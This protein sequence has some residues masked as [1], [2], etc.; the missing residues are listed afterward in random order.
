MQ[1][2][3]CSLWWGYCAQRYVVR[4]L[5]LTKDASE[6]LCN[7]F[8]C[9]DHRASDKRVGGGN[10]AGKPTSHH[11]GSFNILNISARC[12]QEVIPTQNL[13]PS[14]PLTQILAPTRIV[15]AS[16][17]RG[18]HR[19]TRIMPLLSAFSAEQ[20]YSMLQSSPWDT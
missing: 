4:E 20:T 5:I 18:Q 15:V 8:S 16:T 12:H 13:L 14:C 10:C 19:S 3:T 9:V 17:G 1:D 11:T 2:A 7:V 6:D